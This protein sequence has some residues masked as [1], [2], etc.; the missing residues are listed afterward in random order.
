MI[1]LSRPVLALPTRSQEQEGLSSHNAHALRHVILEVTCQHAELGH[2][3][4]WSRQK[5]S[6]LQRYTK[7]SKAQARLRRCSVLRAPSRLQSDR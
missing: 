4:C 6:Q 2:G 3:E 5:F 1:Y 7:L